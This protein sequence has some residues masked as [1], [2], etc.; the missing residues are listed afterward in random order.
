MR[1]LHPRCG[2]LR[3]CGA[4][5]IADPAAELLTLV[6]RSGESPAPA[7]RA[8]AALLRRRF[9]VALP[10]PFVEPTDPGDPEATPVRVAAAHDGP[11]IAAVKWRAFGSCYRG[12]LPDDFLDNREVVPPA[13][14]WIGRAAVPPS[15]RYSLFVLGRP[16]HVLGYC[17]AGPCRDADVDTEV[18]GE[19]YELYLD[20]TLLRAGGGRRL[21]ESA[22]AQ[23]GASGSIDLRLW[24]LQANRAGRSFYEAC[25]WTADGAARSEDLGRAAFEEVRY[26][27]EGRLA[28]TDF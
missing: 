18:T 15:R 8:A 4:I 7:D 22:V 16:G 5:V 14:F 28:V 21:L 25:G 6:Q 27:P 13:A 26:R 19:V 10:P 24:V 12:I 3:E 9:G 17:D 11:A 23:L 1:A 2:Q 20:P